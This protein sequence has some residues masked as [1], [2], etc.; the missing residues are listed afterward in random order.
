MAWRGLKNSRYIARRICGPFCVPRSS[1]KHDDVDRVANRPE[2]LFE[3]PQVNLHQRV[4]EPVRSLRF[5][6]QHHQEVVHAVIEL[7]HLEQIS[8]EQRENCAV[9]LGA[10]RARPCGQL[11]RPGYRWSWRRS[12]SGPHVLRVEFFDA[13]EILLAVEEWPIDLIEV[14][15]TLR[16]ARDHPAARRLATPTP[17]RLARVAPTPAFCMGFRRARSNPPTTCLPGRRLVPTPPYPR[18]AGRARH[19]GR[20][21]VAAQ[22][23]RRPPYAAQ[24]RAQLSASDRRPRIYRMN[25]TLKG[26]PE[27]GQAD[28]D[29]RRKV[30]ALAMLSWTFKLRP[31]DALTDGE[32]PLMR[33]GSACTVIIAPAFAL[34]A[35]VPERSTPLLSKSF[36]TAPCPGDRWCRRSAPPGPR[37]RRAPRVRSLLRLLTLRLGSCIVKRRG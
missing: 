30:R 19:R 7:P 11:C 15:R 8:A 12:N 21:P 31:I 18:P 24:A 23:R 26:P 10:E 32:R 13:G 27:R 34:R 25:G 5:A 28:D 16:H 1:P 6:G 4:E 37:Q 2:E 17:F 3:I 20:S 33:S 36:P 14:Q 29:S 35:G 22:D 9:V